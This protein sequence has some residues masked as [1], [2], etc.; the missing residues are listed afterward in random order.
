MV[1]HLAAML[2]TVVS[3]LNVADNSLQPLQGAVH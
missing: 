3:V 2:V 1:Q